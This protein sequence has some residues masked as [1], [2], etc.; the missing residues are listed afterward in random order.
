MD[1]HGKLWTIDQDQKLMEAPHLSNSYFSRMMGRSEKAILC[2]RSHLAAKMHQD[3]PDTSLEEYV[4]LMHGDLRHAEALLREWG[5]KR[6]NLKSFLDRNKKR[7]QEDLLMDEPEIKQS[8]FFQPPPALDEPVP[9]PVAWSQL[10]TD[11]RIEAICRCIREEQGNLSGVLNDQQFLPL[12]VQHY[13]GF[14]A[15]ARVVQARCHYQQ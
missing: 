1:N 6:A 8:R 11:E 10:G 9:G 3:D 12:L 5:E 13:P 2:R 7:K 4:G 14:E 15:Y